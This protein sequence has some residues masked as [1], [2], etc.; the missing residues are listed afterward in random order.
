[1]THEINYKKVQIIDSD[2]TFEKIYE[3]KYIPS[4]YLDEIKKANLLIVPNENFR[5]KGDVL[6]FPETTRE[7]FEYIQDH[8]NDEIV[9]DIAISDDNFQR[10][11]LHSAVIEVATIIVNV[12]V[13]PVAINMI[14]NYLYDLIKK[15]HRKPED[16]SARLKIISE[17]T[18]TKKTK[19][20]SYEGPV[21]EVKE[22]LEIATKEIFSEDK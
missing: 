19:I 8:P 6:F 21:S 2:L 5:K 17:E 18:K 12:V 3:K 14:S 4:E 20:I 13:L 15:Y 10:I 22:T 11:E 1:M 7:F 9:A 16:T